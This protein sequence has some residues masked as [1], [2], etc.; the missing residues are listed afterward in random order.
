VTAAGTL[1]LLY[2]RVAELDR[3]PYEFAVRPDRFALQCDRLRQRCDVVPL[4]DTNGRAGE[5]AITFDDGYADNAVEARG[6]LASA[7]LPATFFVST[8]RIGERAEIW[9]D[10]LERIVLD[11]E[12]MPDHLEVEIEGRPLWAD[13]R[14]PA[15]RARAHWALYHR[16]RPLRPTVIDGV[17]TALEAQCGADRHD[18]DSRRWMTADEL[19]TLASTPGV[20]VGAHT[21]THP[22]LTS[23]TEPEQRQ[24]I[25]GSRAALEQLL[26]RRVDLFSYPFG[27]H[28][29][30]D[31][32]TA[33]L[34][35]ESGYAMAVTGTGGLAAPEHYPLAVPR[36]VV[37]DWDGEG[38]DRFLN[39]WLG[40][41]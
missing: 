2:H 17:L 9:W 26:E 25:D 8:A 15:A 21:L 18:R 16:L 40:T 19:R 22:L 34:V 30:F 28:E 32:R 29:A 31:A 6:I 10:R 3:D 35:R 39:R 1:V 33:T 4:R 5:V 12:R 11:A 27:G 37:G 36:N 23:L 38:F 20:D 24:E 7:G 13:V 14:S 41:A